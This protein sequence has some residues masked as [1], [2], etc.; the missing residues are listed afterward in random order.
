MAST[1]PKLPVLDAIAR[2]DPDSIAVVHGL[3]GRR[4]KYGELLG[5]VY[6]ARNKLL[7]A[8]GKQ[9]LGGERI[10]FLIENGY[11]YVGKDC[12]LIE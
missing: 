7:E 10:A 8:T 9:D 6:R 11:D 12:P 2:H 4:F 5:D 3:S 1:L